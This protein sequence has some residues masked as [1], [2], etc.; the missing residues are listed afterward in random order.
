MRVN[1]LKRQILDVTGLINVW[2]VKNIKIL[3]GA[4]I[5]LMHPAGLVGKITLLKP[6]N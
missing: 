1:G 3:S 5:V 6:I 4:E 2:L